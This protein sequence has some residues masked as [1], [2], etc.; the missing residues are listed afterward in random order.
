MTKHSNNILCPL[1]ILVI[2]CC[3]TISMADNKSSEA[4]Q[5]KPKLEQELDEKGQ[6]V[7]ERHVH[8]VKRVLIYRHSSCTNCD[9]IKKE[10]TKH[11]IE[12]QDVDLTWNRKQKAI[13]KTKAGKDDASYVFIGN[14]YVGNHEDLKGLM[15]EG[16]LFRM[17]EG[18]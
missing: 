14:E 11:K 4:M 10:L 5:K 8:Q 9:D 15:N 13:L 1:L 7:E 12:Y 16:R 17:L 18:E 2:G 3:S 6:V